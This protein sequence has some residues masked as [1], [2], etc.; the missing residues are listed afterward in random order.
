M[1]RDMNDSRCAITEI[2]FQKITREEIS[3]R[4]TISVLTVVGVSLTTIR[5]AGG[6]DIGPVAQYFQ[7]E[8]VKSLEP[9][10]NSGIEGGNGECKRQAKLTKTW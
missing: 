8:V 7:I 1:V 2:F 10:K 5:F 9:R 4:E 3:V 6:G